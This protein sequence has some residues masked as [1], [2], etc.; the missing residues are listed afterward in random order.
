[1]K[2]K[3]LIIASILVASITLPSIYLYNIY[4]PEEIYLEGTVT[5]VYIGSDIAFVGIN[6]TDGEKLVYTCYLTWGIVLL[7]YSNESQIYRFHLTKS[8]KSDEC[9]NL[10]FEEVEQK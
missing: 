4:K 8:S 10:Y 9:Y 1:M 6:T 2:T 7:Q 3:T 5:G